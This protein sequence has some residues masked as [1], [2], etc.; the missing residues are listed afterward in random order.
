MWKCYLLGTCD[1]G[2]QKTYVGITPDLDRRLKQHNGLMSGGAKATHGRTWKRLCHVRGFPDHVA[3][4]QFEWRWKQ[5]SRMMD[6]NPLQRRFRAL[7]K[8]M[9]LDRPTTAAVAYE[10]YEEPL[11]YIEEEEIKLER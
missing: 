3:A 8:L 2:S 1:G 9:S 10:D 6:G 5:I 11:E 7:D 4:L